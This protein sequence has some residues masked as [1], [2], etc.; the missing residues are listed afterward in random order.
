MK[1]AFLLFV[2]FIASA[3]IARAETVHQQLDVKILTE[4]ADR[5]IVMVGSKF[6][7][8][9]HAHVTQ[10]ITHFEQLML[11]DLV[12]FEKTSDER[13]FTPVA[14][15]TDFDEVLTLAPKHAGEIEI[16]PVT[17]DAINAVT[18]LASKFSSTD[19]VVIHVLPSPQPK[20]I[21]AAWKMAHYAAIVAI[22][23]AVA[24]LTFQIGGMFLTWCSEL[25]RS[26]RVAAGGTAVRPTKAAA[27]SF[28]NGSTAPTSCRDLDR[29][30]PFAPICRRAALGPA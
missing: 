17:I 3:G 19:S 5:R 16:G 10:Q 27:S 8:R 25:S 15:G 28:E 24:V 22:V 4:T 11:P 2:V 20:F 21:A 9:I 6:H 13:H 14:G 18:V 30:R 1:R 23:L 7:L 26:K 29:T 12:A